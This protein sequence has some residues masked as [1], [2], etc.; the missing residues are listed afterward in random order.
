MHCPHF[1]L[2]RQQVDYVVPSSDD[3]DLVQQILLFPLHIE[4]RTPIRKWR[5]P[6]IR[7]EAD[8]ETVSLAFVHIVDFPVSNPCLVD[9]LLFS[10]VKGS[11]FLCIDT[12]NV[13]TQAQRLGERL[14]VLS[15]VYSVFVGHPH[16]VVRRPNSIVV[17]GVNIL[18]IASYICVTYR[19]VGRSS[20]VSNASNAASNFAMISVED[21][22]VGVS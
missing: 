11:V 6:D 13:D 3:M 4:R 8:N 14:A 1:V 22:I 5:D 17:D 2:E 16:Q 12:S 18:A 10:A 9:S 19:S 15:C 20:V 21:V 7:D